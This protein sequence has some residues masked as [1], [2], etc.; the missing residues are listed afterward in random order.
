MASIKINVPGLNFTMVD[1][2]FIDNYL[3]DARG[4]FIKIYIYLLRIGYSNLSMG[5]DEISSALNILQTDVQ[6]G[7]EYWEGKGLIKISSDGN[8]TIDMCSPSQKEIVQQNVLFDNPVKD[9]FNGIENLLGRPLSSKELSVFMSFIEEYKFPT[10]LIFIL[11][12][13]CISK[14]KTDIRYIEKVAISWHEAGIRSLEDAQRHISKFED[15]WTKYRV[16]IHYM[17]LKD[18][19]ISKPQEEMLEK[20]LLKFNMPID[21]VQEACKISVLRIN[22][23]N[24]KYIDTIL[25][26]WHGKDINSVDDLKKLEKKSKPYKRNPQGNQASTTNAGGSNSTNKRQYDAGELEKLLLGRGVKNEK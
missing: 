7:L 1:N 6:K 25:C 12:E 26:D 9:M 11:L 23:C 2:A 21:L 16:I 18:N 20:W 5:I 4:D 17:G 15:K 24:F 19:E 10:E 3:I 8:G 14:R 22:E 13:Y